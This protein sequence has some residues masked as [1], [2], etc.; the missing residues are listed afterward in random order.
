MNYKNKLILVTGGTGFV[1]TNFVEQLIKKGAKIRVPIHNREMSIEHDLIE[2]MYNVDLKDTDDCDRVMQGV[3]YVFHLAGAVGNPSTVNKGLQIFTDNIILTAN[4]LQAAWGAGVK[5]F[6]YCSSSTGYPDRRY[7][8]KENE[9][10]NDQPHPSYF[11]YGHMRRYIELLTEFTNNQ[12]D[13]EIALVR[14]TVTY[15]PHD[16]FDLKTCHV[17]PALIKKAL[18]NMNPYEVWGTGDVV[19]DF[20]YIKDFV[21]GSIDVFE[22]GK[23]MDPFNIGYGSTVTI[24]DVVQAVL[25]ATNKE[26]LTVK[27]NTSKPTTIPFRMVNTEKSK[28]QLNFIPK[29]TLQE[30]INETV[31]WYIKNQK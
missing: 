27:Y 10:W 5:K 8:I 31:E 4:C 17:I 13:M 24:D 12:S 19:R 2:K 26:N 29:Y 15:G 16:N 28:K 11:G 6:L 7:A 30:G 14:A 3:D 20:L 18:D 25:K 21:K 1:G 23:S 22:K 9:F